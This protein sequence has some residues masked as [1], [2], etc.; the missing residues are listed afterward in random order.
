V[1]A[2]D[3]HHLA[4]A[5]PVHDGRLEPLPD[6]RDFQVVAHPSATATNVVLP[7]LIVVKV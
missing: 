4:T 7:G 6:Q 3:G 5:D 2:E 1:P